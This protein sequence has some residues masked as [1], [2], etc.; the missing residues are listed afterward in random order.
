MSTVVFL[1]AHPDDEAIFTGGT[2]RLLA[3][4]TRSG[5]IEVLST[6]PV[7]PWQIVVG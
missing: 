6:M 7:N 3:E 1:H 5:N 4:E 2:M